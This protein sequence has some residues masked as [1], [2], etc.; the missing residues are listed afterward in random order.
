[1]SSAFLRKSFFLIVAIYAMSFAVPASPPLGSDWMLIGAKP[2]PKPVFGYKLFLVGMIPTPFTLIWLANPLL[3]Y[4]LWKFR[5]GK[6]KPA[7]IA[8]SV[9]AVLATAW[10]P[11]ALLEEQGLTLPDGKLLLESSGFLLWWSS[12]I[13]AAVVSF[14]AR[15]AKAK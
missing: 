13:I 5:R 12:I 10:I 7:L 1:M 15:A 8:S 9:A 2:K 3:W 4:A 14:F 6:F 11:F